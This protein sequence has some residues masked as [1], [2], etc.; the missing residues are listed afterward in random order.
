MLIWS[1]T[2][3]PIKDTD[4]SIYMALKQPAWL[5]DWDIMRQFILMWF[6]HATFLSGVSRATFAPQGL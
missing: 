4:I 1:Y 6:E 5:I 2:Y 3:M